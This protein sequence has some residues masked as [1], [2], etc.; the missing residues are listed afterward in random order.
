MLKDAAAQ[1]LLE[2]GGVTAISEPDPLHELVEKWTWWLGDP[3]AR[4]A[5]GRAGRAQIRCGAADE[6]VQ[7]LERLLGIVAVKD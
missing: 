1:P 2:S 7:A 4:S 3:N 5:A 6:S